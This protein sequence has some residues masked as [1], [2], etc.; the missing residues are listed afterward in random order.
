MTIQHMD[1]K[2]WEHHIVHTLKYYGIKPLDMK[3]KTTLTKTSYNQTRTNDWKT[4]ENAT[5]DGDVF[6][7]R[8]TSPP[9][10]ARLDGLFFKLIDVP[11]DPSPA[12]KS[13]RYLVFL[14]LAQ[15][16]QLMT[17][18]EGIALWSWNTTNGW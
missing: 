5:V 8:A 18:L 2:Q 14:S 7:V 16:L 12:P 6:H 11:V 9:R 4:W 15:W 13:W 10:V 1:I 17:I 3:C